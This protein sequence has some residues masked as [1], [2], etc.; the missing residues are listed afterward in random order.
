MTLSMKK[1]K[2]L[3]VDEETDMQIFL[4]RVLE[5]GGYEPVVAGDGQS[6]LRMALAEKPALVILDLM[7]TDQA[8]IQMLHDLR[9]TEDLKDIPVITLST[10][11]HK[12]F[13]QYQ[14]LAGVQAG[15]LSIQPEVYLE[16]P[17]ETEELLHLLARLTDLAEAGEPE[18]G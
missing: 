10:I 14:T 13:T 17:P 15:G 6:G 1:K 12:T 16:K 11:D 8:G 4:T 18:E 3:V 9:N 7:M 5:T 2:I